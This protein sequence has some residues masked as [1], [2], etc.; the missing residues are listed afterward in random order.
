MWIVGI[1][2]VG[3]YQGQRIIFPRK[4]KKGRQDINSLIMEAQAMVSTCT[5][6]EGLCKE[7]GKFNSF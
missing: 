2:T 5:G 4:K 1:S 7:N 3:I 6:G